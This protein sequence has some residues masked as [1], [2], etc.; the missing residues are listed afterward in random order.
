[1]NLFPY[2]AAHAATHDDPIVA[3][4]LAKAAVELQYADMLL[5]GLFTDY[6]GVCF[7]AQ[8]SIEKLFKAALLSRRAPAPRSHDL[9]EL[10]KAVIDV[11]PSWTFDRKT[12][13]RITAGAVES[14]YPRFV[15][16]R[17]TAAEFL[18]VAVAVWNSL[19]PLV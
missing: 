8:Q 18:S 16:N 17:E 3:E 14:R 15:S 10:R 11:F 5:L 12:V 19:R 7:F 1:M 6:Y 2:T 13:A 9:A 4:W